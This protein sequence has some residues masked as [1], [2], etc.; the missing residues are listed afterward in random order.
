M[1]KTRFANCHGLDMLNN[2]SCCEDVLIMTQEALKNEEFRKIVKA[3]T[4]KGLF[5]FFREGKVV[6][7]PV[8]W[9]NTNK[10]LEKSNIVGVKTGIT[11]KAGGCLSTSFVGNN[12]EEGII[13]VLGSASAEDRFRDTLQI[14]K[15]AE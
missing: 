14:L 3:Q 8:Y 7:K 13:V 15:W 1:Y 10:L 6:C 11:N 9:T 4:H 2:Y 5:K 12:G